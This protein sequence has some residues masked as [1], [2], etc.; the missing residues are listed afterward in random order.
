LF[1]PKAAVISNATGSRSRSNRFYYILFFW[2]LLF[3]SKTYL[4]TRVAKPIAVI[5]EK[6]LSTCGS[7]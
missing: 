4:I 2:Q 5:C 6:T 1:L 3:V 7:Q